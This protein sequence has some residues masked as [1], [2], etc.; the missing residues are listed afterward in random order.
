MARPAAAAWSSA[1]GSPGFSAADLERVPRVLRSTRV[2]LLLA[3]GIDADRLCGN[4]PDAATARFVGGLAG[5]QWTFLSLPRDRDRLQRSR[6]RARGGA[7]GARGAAAIL[8][9]SRSDHLFGVSDPC[10]DPGFHVLV[11]VGLRALAATGGAGALGALGRGVLS[12]TCLHPEFSHRG[13]GAAPGYT[14]SHRIGRVLARDE[15][16][17]HRRRDDSGKHH[18]SLRGDLRSRSGSVGAS[19]MAD[20]AELADSRSRFVGELK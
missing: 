20:A 16:I 17:G 1:L 15:R 9:G 5:A 12:R 13:S 8:L 6:G 2:D 3:N 18:G 10:G 4:E 19:G 11:R 7:G 14:R